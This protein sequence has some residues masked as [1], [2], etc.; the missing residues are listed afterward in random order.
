MEHPNEEDGAV[1]LQPMLNVDPH[2]AWL[3]KTPQ[4]RWDYDESIGMVRNL[5]G[6]RMYP[7][8]LAGRD[9]AMRE[10]TRKR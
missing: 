9:E 3:N 1:W 4:E 6:D 7:L 2:A 5:M 10:L 8:T